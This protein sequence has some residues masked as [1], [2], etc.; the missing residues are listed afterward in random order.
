MRLTDIL[1]LEGWFGHVLANMPQFAFRQD[2]GTLHGGAFSM[3]DISGV[4]PDEVRSD[5]RSFMAIV[6]CYTAEAANEYASNCPDGAEIGHFADPRALRRLLEDKLQQGVRFI[7]SPTAGQQGST[8]RT[9]ESVI[10]I[11]R[12]HENN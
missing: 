11:L 1:Q 7:V 4:P 2:N 3:S 10:S 6:L 9:I 5:G 8:V 12:R